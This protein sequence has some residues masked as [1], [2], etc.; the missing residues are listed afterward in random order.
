MTL[1]DGAGLASSRR[2]EEVYVRV[3]RAPVAE[4]GPDRIVCP[5]DPVAFDAG[6][7][8]DED[9]RL[10]GYRWTFSDGVVLEGPQVERSFA[11]PGARLVQLT[12]TDDSG[13]ACAAGIDSAAVLVNSPP[14]V[15]AGPDRDTPVG[16]ANDTLVFDAGAASD[17][18]GQGVRVEWDFGDGTLAGNAVTRH[19][20]G[21]PGEYTVRVDARDTTG[22]ACGVASDTAV[23]RARARE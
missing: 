12:V 19:R 2:T 15:D 10:T 13:S 11:T 21:A 22:L 20:Y 18:D 17:P 4:A 5:G 6:L 8:A 14:V 9:G 23:V 7:S 1:D 16:A 3:N